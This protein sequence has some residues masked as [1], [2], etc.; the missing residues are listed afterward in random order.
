MNRLTRGKVIL[1]L[2]AIFLAGAGAGAVGGYTVARHKNSRP[3]Q[4][5]DVA[6]QIRARLQ[7]RLELTPEQLEKIDP[8]IQQRCANY[9]TM[10]RCQTEEMTRIVEK[11]NRQVAGI[12]TLEQNRKFAAMERERQER[13]GRHGKRQTD[14]KPV[15]AEKD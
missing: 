15:K 3:A 5:T 8:F 4:R 14:R 7:E 2:T 1:Y 10:Q 12:L 6:S 11:F 9:K 13:T